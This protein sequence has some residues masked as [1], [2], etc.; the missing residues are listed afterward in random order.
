MYLSAHYLFALI[1]RKVA[2]VV[3]LFF[4]GL[5]FRRSQTKRPLEPRPPVD[6]PLL[7]K[8]RTPFRVLGQVHLIAEL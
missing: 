7:Q 3:V 1:V 8:L 5:A 4:L 6:W 2:I